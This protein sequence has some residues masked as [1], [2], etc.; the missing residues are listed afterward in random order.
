MLPLTSAPRDDA[1]AAQLG[2]AVH[3]DAVAAVVERHVVADHGPVA[4]VGDVDAVLVDRAGGDVVLDQ[5]V[6]DEAGEDAPVAVVVR[7]NIADRDVRGERRSVN[8]DRCERRLAA[9]R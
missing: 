9:C 5:Q 4:A 3:V 6:V 1:V 8:A 2:V 7:L